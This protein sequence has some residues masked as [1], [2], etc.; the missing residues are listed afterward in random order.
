[1]IT[2]GGQRYRIAEA[3]ERNAFILDRRG[4]EVES[5]AEVVTTTAAV[6]PSPP[7][8]KESVRHEKK[9]WLNKDFILILTKQH[10]QYPYFMVAVNNTDL[11]IRH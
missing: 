10:A 3:S 8:E 1:M 6:P 4:A 11:M 5:Q 7:G 2:G 9:L